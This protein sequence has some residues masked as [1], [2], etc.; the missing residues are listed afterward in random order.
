[1]KLVR[2]LQKLKSEYVQIELKNG[3]VI[4]G[5]VV[6]VSNTMNTTLK[7]ARM[8]VVD[9]EPVG[10]ETVNIRGNTIRHYILPDELPLDALI[11]NDGPK[12]RSHLP[13]SKRARG[14][15]RPRRGRRA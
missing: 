5:T 4:S 1:M 7:N 8:T 12:P 10:L 15:R 6:Q 11:A 13:V 3:T 2:F 14:G 9:R